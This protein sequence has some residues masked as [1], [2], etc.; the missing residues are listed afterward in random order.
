LLRTDSTR[1]TSSYH[2][3]GVTTD[4][5]STSLFTRAAYCPSEKTIDWSCGSKC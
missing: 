1:K 4:V 5:L 3:L 2:I